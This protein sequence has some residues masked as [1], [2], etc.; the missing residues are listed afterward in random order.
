MRSTIAACDYT[1]NKG[2]FLCSIKNF[3]EKIGRGDTG[4]TDFSLIGMRLQR[5]C[6]R[7]RMGERVVATPMTIERRTLM[8][9]LV[10]IPK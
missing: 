1:I 8:N 5:T 2:V 6:D 7:V 9:K 4:P 3:K 10:S